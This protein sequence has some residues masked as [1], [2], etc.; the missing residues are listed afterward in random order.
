MPQSLASRS[1]SLA[2]AAAMSRHPAAGARGPLPTPGGTA[3]FATVAALLTGPW[4][5]TDPLG[6]PPRPPRGERAGALARAAAAPPADDASWV[7][8][9]V[10]DG[11]GG[12]AGIGRAPLSRPPG[13]FLRSS[14]RLAL[15]A[16]R[17]RLVGPARADE[18]L[19][20]P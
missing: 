7:V 11:R 19:A 10:G 15:G 6:F 3:S 9:G 13:A 17:A 4:R 1:D 5:G 16:L 18:G 14:V 8:V 20:S 2:L 12:V